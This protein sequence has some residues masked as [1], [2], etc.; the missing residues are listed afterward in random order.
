MGLFMRPVDLRAGM[1]R[2][3]FGLNL[4]R[5]GRGLSRPNP[6]RSRTSR[7]PLRWEGPWKQRIGAAATDWCRSPA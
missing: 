1:G 7:S 3:A 6:A 2:Y 5:A 4:R